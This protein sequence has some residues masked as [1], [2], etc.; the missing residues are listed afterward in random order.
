MLQRSG[1]TDWHWWPVAAGIRQLD[2]SSTEFLRNTRPEQTICVRTGW[3]ESTTSCVPFSFPATAVATPVTGGGAAGSAASDPVLT[4]P[5]SSMLVGP[6]GATQVSWT[7]GSSTG[8]YVNLEQPLGRPYRSFFQG[9]GTS[10]FLLGHGVLRAGPTFVCVGNAASTSPSCVQLTR[11]G[12]PESAVASVSSGM[13]RAGKLRLT[14]A[15]IS[16]VRDVRVRVQVRQGSAWTT[17]GTTSVRV[18]AGGGRASFSLS[19]RWTAPLGRNIDVRTTV[20]FGNS[21]K[22]TT[23]RLG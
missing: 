9:A 1:T 22:T 20:F 23:S 11:A 7:G 21:A 16:T 2:V 15:V 18:P 10:S 12:K 17:L 8:V 13:L 19:R 6:R 5:R 3:E 4:A 14:G